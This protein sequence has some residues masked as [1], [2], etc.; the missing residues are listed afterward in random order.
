MLVNTNPELI[1]SFPH[2]WGNQG[3]TLFF[4]TP[5]TWRSEEG[6]GSCHWA[7]CEPGESQRK[8]GGTT[9]DTNHR[10]GEV[11]RVLT[12]WYYTTLWVLMLFKYF[13]KAFAFK[14]FK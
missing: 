1:V 4:S 8:D 9:E 5:Q 2:A 12:R 10:P 6:S 14:N 3:S 7:D 11:H 13:C